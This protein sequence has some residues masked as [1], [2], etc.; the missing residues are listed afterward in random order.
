MIRYLK[1][2]LWLSVVWHHLYK[3]LWMVT[4]KAKEMTTDCMLIIWHTG[5]RH[6]CFVGQRNS[7][8][9]VWLRVC[10]DLVER[11]REHSSCHALPVIMRPATPLGCLELISLT[12]RM[13]CVS[14]FTTVQFVHGCNPLVF[15]AI[16]ILYLFDMVN[17]VAN[18]M[19]LSKWN[20]ALF[21][22]QVSRAHIPCRRKAKDKTLVF[23]IY[24]HVWLR[25]STQLKHGY[26]SNKYITGIW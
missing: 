1:E 14:S 9:C 5:K 3:W 4:W 2:D 13:S 21:D 18:D 17:P 6:T 26:Y 20:D 19:W 7:R 8:F 15:A 25:E 11:S 23:H 12:T 22:P 16:T 10:E 24:F